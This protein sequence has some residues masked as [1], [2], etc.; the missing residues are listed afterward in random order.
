MKPRARTLAGA[1]LLDL[2][3]GD[4]VGLPHPVRAI[5]WAIA[6]CEERWNG[7]ERG[8]RLRGALVTS[9]IIAATFAAALLA[10]R[11]A[12]RAHPMLAEI[13]SI[14]LA[15]SALATTDLVRE[16]QAVSSALEANDI[17]RARTCVARIV[18]R[19][20]SEL[21]ASEVAR[22][23]IETL[24]ESAS[25][26]IVAP[27]LWGLLG[28]APAALAFKAISTL[29]S[30]IGYRDARYA[31]FGAFAARVDDAANLIPARITAFLIAALS[32]APLRAARTTLADAGAH[33]SPNAGWPEAAMAGALGV[34]LGGTNVYDGTQLHG[35]TFMAAGR[36]AEPR[37]VRHA[38]AL[39]QRVSFAGALLAVAVRA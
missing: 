17:D 12:R 6:R 16:A 10:E 26:G 1:Y 34:R 38:I 20:T 7:M 15:A 14:V 35:P 30:M 25:D 32:A 24:A 2:A 9:G 22:A 18:G 31:R 33:P 29:D 3:I 21:N 11:A 23:A 39:V 5:G 28:G 4:P 36:T 13:V 27:L 8:A 19:E 37:D